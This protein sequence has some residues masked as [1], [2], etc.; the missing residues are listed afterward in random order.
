MASKINDHNGYVPAGTPRLV[1]S[2]AGR[3][4]Q[5]VVSHGESTAQTVTLYDG[6]NAAANVLCVLKI[7]SGSSPDVLAFPKDLELCF[8]YGLFV[9]PGLCEVLISGVIE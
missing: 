5:V 9:D 2:G 6:L 8:R 3:I 4:R 1:A 7:A